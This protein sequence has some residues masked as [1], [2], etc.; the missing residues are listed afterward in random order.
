MANN[1]KTALLCAYALASAKHYAE[2]ESLILSDAEVAKT[3]E[4]LDLLARVRAEQG[5]VAEARRLW[6]EILLTQP[7]NKAAKAALRN[8][9]KP[10][11]RRWL[12]ALGVA[13]GWVAALVVGLAVGLVVGGLCGGILVKA[14]ADERVMQIEAN[15]LICVD[16]LQWA[17]IPTA[18]ELAALKPYRGRVSTVTLGSAFFADPARSAQRAVLTAMVAEA[19]GLPESNVFLGKPPAN[20]SEGSIHVRLWK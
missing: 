1:A 5:D 9:G 3:P 17:G 4:A 16:R 2:A 7:D 13:G 8:L 11:R 18:R 14:F 6:R 15:A 10:P 20:A 12:L 19:L